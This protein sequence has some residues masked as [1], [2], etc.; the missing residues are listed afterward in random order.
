MA[1]LA[2]IWIT[3]PRTASKHFEAIEHEEKKSAVPVDSLL[4][5]DQCKLFGPHGL[6]DML[7]S[8]T[9]QIHHLYGTD[10]CIVAVQCIQPEH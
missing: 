8:T 5:R 9:S 6:S 4:L 7:Q 10:A 3:N 2:D 1:P